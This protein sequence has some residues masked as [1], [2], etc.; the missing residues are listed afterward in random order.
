MA[1]TLIDMFRESVERYPATPLFLGKRKE[2][3]EGITY[4]EAASLVRD[5]MGGLRAIGVRKGHRIAL[6]SEN[7]PEWALMD[8]AVI[9]SGAVNVALFPTLPAV[10]VEHILTDSGAGILVVSNRGQA[11][12]ALEIKRRLP[13][14]VIVA[15]ESAAVQDGMLSF[16]GLL[17]EGRK[18]PLPDS[19]YSDLTN[20]VKPGD[21][22]A[23]VYTS[24]T[25]GEPKGAILSHRNFSSN[26]EAAW[27]VIRF[28]EGERLLSFLPLNHVMGRLVDHYLAMRCGST[29][30]YAESL[31][32][33]RQNLLEI[34][35]S[36]MV[37]VP[38]VLDMFKEGVL[39]NVRK[40]GGLKERLFNWALA[41]GI[42]CCPYT[43]RGEKI[44]LLSSLL[45]DLADALVLSKIRAALGLEN[46]R[47][48][49]AGGAPLSPETARFFYALRL[50]IMEGYG[51]TET[52][53]LVTVNPQ[54]RQKFGTVGPAVDGVEV[55]IAGDGEIM[56]RGPNVMEGYYGKPE[57]T[58]LAIDGEGWF[59]T[60]DI[61]E[62][63]GDGYLKITDRKKNLLVLS[64]G[65]KVAPQPI[66]ASLSESP[67][68]SQVILFGD[69]E[70]V[71][72]GLIV[73]SFA[74]LQEWMKETRRD[75]V[76]DRRVMVDHPA[77][78]SLIQA[79]IERLSGRLADFEKVR[80]FTL[81]DEEFSVENGM[82]TPT[83]KVR[84][85]AVL[86]R[87]GDRIAAMY[88][89]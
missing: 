50:R 34:K 52:S 73:P 81:L 17:E 13:R 23:V 49:F 37:L 43:E 79:E 55:R 69:H 89:Q 76:S 12:K 48:F 66:E 11:A 41:R 28:R 54:D 1:R 63:D 84:R 27:K 51:L 45:W 31:L 65:K 77:V 88:R 40:T 6:L 82:L 33:L 3:W 15:I 32:R 22:A 14:L 53:P 78:R 4:G 8:L 71:V 58:A 9:H 46:I 16:G 5:L 74:A 20:A 38:R 59:H 57:D 60:G 80:R 56:V 86:E 85:A 25:T 67:Y 19:L 68:I 24:G 18:H 30:A 35:P 42:C 72:S 83:L 75:I 10:Q 70:S 21:P 61:G 64:T 2:V 87:Y 26:V 44:P 36:Y 62:L 47:F 29:V 7:R 39:T